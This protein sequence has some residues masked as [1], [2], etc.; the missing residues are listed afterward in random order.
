[1]FAQQTKLTAA[2]T[3]PQ[4]GRC[5]KHHHTFAWEREG[6]Y[7]AELTGSMRDPYWSHH[8]NGDEAM[9]QKLGLKP[10]PPP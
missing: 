6:Q 2:P 5:H 10:L 1:M 4:R 9:L 3:G 7:R 8:D